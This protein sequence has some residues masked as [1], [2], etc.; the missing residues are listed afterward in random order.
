MII[1]VVLL[2]VLLTLAIIGW[3]AFKTMAKYEAALDNHETFAEQGQTSD[4]ALLYTALGGKDS[5]SPGSRVWKNTAPPPTV[6]TS[7]KASC[8]DDDRNIEFSEKPTYEP[9][10]G[11]MMR[12]TAGKGPLSHV[13]DIDLNNS[14]SVCVVYHTRA[15]D[16]PNGSVL[17]LFA[18][19]SNN[20]GLHIYRESGTMNLQFGALNPVSLQEDG[21]AE[22]ADQY[23]LLVITRDSSTSKVRA[24]SID[25]KVA[26]YV[27]RQT[28]L[29]NLQV[30][31]DARV[32]LSN[33][34]VSINGDAKW[35]VDLLELRFTR[36]YMSN[37]DIQTYAETIREKLDNYDPAKQRLKSLETRIQQMSQCPYDKN[38]CAVCGGVQDW[39]NDS[40]PALTGGQ[41]CLSAINRFCSSN[42]T[43]DKCKCWDATNA[44]YDTACRTYRAI[45]DPSQARKC[46]KPKPL[47]KPKPVPEPKPGGGG[48]GGGCPY[49]GHHHKKDREH[50][51]DWA[52]IDAE[53]ARI[54]AD[55]DAEA[56]ANSDRD[57]D[58]E[59]IK[60]I[61][62]DDN[63]DHKHDK[64][65]DHSLDKVDAKRKKYRHSHKHVHKKHTYSDRD[66]PSPSF[67]KWLI[68][69]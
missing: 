66:E 43:H 9:G 45:Y 27:D 10:K 47:P 68:S 69:G 24:V 60:L 65:F 30:P 1:V 46:P 15:G 48:G 53:A 32:P 37:R 55:L 22:A 63:H 29:A 14:F 4:L 6:S 36:A 25:L 42:P 54:E 56:E 67:W 2:L 44:E 33:K 49:D 8:I 58:E 64:D 52:E 41:Q 17:Q 35:N 28:E 7:V 13:L 62:T 26:D 20:N 5:Y 12:H 11:I 34:A 3:L 38:T 23:V 31:G 21:D 18:N 16:N 57:F 59:D 40:L 19:T 39:T 61:Y 50:H 51:K